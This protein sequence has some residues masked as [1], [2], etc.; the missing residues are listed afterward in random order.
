MV[1]MVCGIRL[2]LPLIIRLVS[3]SELDFAKRP[4]WPLFASHKLVIVEYY[5]VG[6]FL[7]ILNGCITKFT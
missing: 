1:D 5:L 6:I 4:P 2:L 3:E 7:G